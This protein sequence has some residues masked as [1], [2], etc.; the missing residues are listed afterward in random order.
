MM[1]DQ[2]YKSA[3]IQGLISAID[4]IE[5]QLK[6]LRGYEVVD[7]FQ[8]RFADTLDPNL[9]LWAF[10][11]DQIQYGRTMIAVQD[12]IPSV[13][14]LLLLPADELAHPP[15][16]ILNT[17]GA[18]GPRLLLYDIYPLGDTTGAAP[19]S[20]MA[21][22]RHQLCSEP[23]SVDT[24]P[25]QM[26]SM[27]GAQA[28]VWKGGSFQTFAETGR[29]IRRLFA[30]WLDTLAES[31]TLATA[32]QEAR[33]QRR[34]RYLSGLRSGEARAR[35]NLVALL[36]SEEAVDPFLEN[37]YFP[38]PSPARPPQDAMETQP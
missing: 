24:L 29:D 32:Q 37:F 31:A 8:A 1:N 9:H 26:T 36:G 23:L 14:S 10:R 2:T 5:D 28:W 3:Y 13:V 15:L 17:F 11:S 18:A 22:A 25:P 19:L 6:Q 21:D 16:A 38:S 7:N 35:Q 4:Q 12:A 20:R 27:M 34:Q 30:I 33:R